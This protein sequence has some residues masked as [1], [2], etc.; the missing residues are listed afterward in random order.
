MRPGA[1]VGV[2]QDAPGALEGEVRVFRTGRNVSREQVVQLVPDRHYGY[3]MLSSAGGLLRDYRGS[4]DLEPAAGG[5][6]HIRWRGTWRPPAPVLG[7]MMECYLR[8]FQQRTVDGLAQYAERAEQPNE[9]S[10]SV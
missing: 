5:G 9:P 6:T 10:G 8:R 1:D 4:V 7:W 3:V 2:R